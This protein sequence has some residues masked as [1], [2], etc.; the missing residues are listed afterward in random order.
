MP[1][2]SAVLPAVETHTVNGRTVTSPARPPKPSRRRTPASPV[3]RPLVVRPLDHP[4]NITPASRVHLGGIPATDDDLA[5]LAA[6]A[7]ALAG[8]LADAGDPAYAH[9]ARWQR[10]LDDVRRS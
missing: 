3:V 9:A 5:M 4:A 2:P 10:L 1:S 8:R 7:G 6:A